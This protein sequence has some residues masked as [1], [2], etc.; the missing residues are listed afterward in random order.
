M[1]AML[2][3]SNFLLRG[4]VAVAAG[5]EPS[6]SIF[7]GSIPAQPPF[8]FRGCISERHELHLHNLRGGRLPKPE[9]A[10]PRA[11][12]SQGYANSVAIRPRPL[13]ASFPVQFLFS[14]PPARATNY[15]LVPFRRAAISIRSWLFVNERRRDLLVVGAVVQSM[16]WAIP[17]PGGIHGAK[18]TSAPAGRDCCRPRWRR[19]TSRTSI[20]TKP[21]PTARPAK[22]HHGLK[23]KE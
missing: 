1:R 2:E 18:H 8:P 3:Y 14:N 7:V 15:S 17:S 23:T 16:C 13:S 22:S 11:W 9:D 19:F 6:S 12:A 21:P 4:F 5:H 20:R 10:Q